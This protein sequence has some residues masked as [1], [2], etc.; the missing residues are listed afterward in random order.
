MVGV[1]LQELQKSI[2]ED[3]RNA[4]DKHNTLT[5]RME[6]MES[7]LVVVMDGLKFAEEAATGF[8]GIHFRATRERV[9][10]LERLAARR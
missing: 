3:S 6:V 1:E 2:Q 10:R 5:G 8:K 7:T 4:Q 9:V